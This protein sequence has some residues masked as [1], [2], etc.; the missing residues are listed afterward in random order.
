[1][2]LTKP[3]ISHAALTKDEFDVVF[4][5]VCHMSKT[6]ARQTF[7]DKER[8]LLDQVSAGLCEAQGMTQWW[9]N[10]KPFVGAW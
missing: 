2:D 10:T 7:T 9:D 8:W 6:G 4:K 3:N 1:M 5:A